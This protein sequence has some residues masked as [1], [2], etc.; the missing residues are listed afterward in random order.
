MSRRLASGLAMT[1][2]V[3]VIAVVILGTVASPVQAQGRWSGGMMDHGL[4]Y[5]FSWFRMIL[6]GVFGIGVILALVL[7]LVWLWRRVSGTRPAVPST[8]QPTAP[9][10]SPKEILQIRYARGE[11]TREQYLQMLEDL[12]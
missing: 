7:L 9:V 2:G 1:L 10:A 6:T 4:L 8:L 5:G 11:I 3:I 12:A